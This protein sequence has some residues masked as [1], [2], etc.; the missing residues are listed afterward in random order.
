M[1]LNQ[2]AETLETAEQFL[3][4]KLTNLI[5]DYKDKRDESKRMSRRIKFSGIVIAGAT[6]ILIGVG[7]YVVN[8]AWASIMALI[9]SA[10][11]TMLSAWDGVEGHTWKWVAYRTMLSRLRNIE[12]ELQFLK[13]NNISIDGDEARRIFNAIESVLLKSNEAW[14]NTRAN[15]L[16]TWA[17]PAGK[18]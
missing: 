4:K 2:T 18:H 8:N 6:T 12:D 10:T 15:N 14:E 9:F 5:S 3:R 11:A 13:A 17:Q 1:D 7:G 16:L